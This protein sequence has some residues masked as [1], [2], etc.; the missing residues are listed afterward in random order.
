MMERIR[1]LTAG[2][3]HGQ[4]LVTILEGM[5]AGLPLEAAAIAR[6]LTRRQR[7][8]GRGG[9]MQIEKDQVQILSG[10]RYGKTLGS[11]IALELQNRD[12]PNWTQKMAVE[13]AAEPA[14]ALHMPRP[15]HA[16]FAGMIKYRQDDLRNILERSSA[17]ETAA[18]VA[19]GAV[20]RS[21]LGH[22]GIE[23]AS[24]VTAIRGIASGFS[25]AA[26]FAGKDPREAAVRAAWHDAL[27]AV[28]ASPLA[29]PDARAE[30]EM[31]AAI[32]A[33]RAEGDSLG[34]VAEIVVLGLM[35]GLGSHVHWDRRLDALL[36]GAL[37]S[38]P[39]IKAV[40][41]GLGC[42]AAREP[43]SKIHDELFYDPERG[44]SRGSNN[45][46]GLE[47]G[48]SNGEPL[49]LRVHMKPLP[50]LARPLRSVDV[51]TLQP[52]SAH[53]ERADVCAVPAAAVVAEAMTALVLADALCL[54]LGGDSLSE[55]EINYRNLAHVPLGW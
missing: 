30:G 32:D 44:Y 38:I 33:A 12:W 40:E 37:M 51:A 54:K 53:H 42:A 17:R 9:R 3:S 47:G 50:T 23:I 43:G 27:A 13:A 25:A 26:F 28:E 4:A 29:C 20:A 6:D 22:F 46:G 39:A 52:C 11:P 15:G 35:P 14:A 8:Y 19:A 31:I 24:H 45:A 18:R 7:G 10:V 49:I 16:D 36:A 2:E 5:P 48:M 41:A 21:L 55:M 1:F 34:G